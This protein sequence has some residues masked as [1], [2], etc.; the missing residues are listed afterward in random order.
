MYVKIDDQTMEGILR[1][2]DLDKEFSS[3]MKL[4]M[5]CKLSQHSFIP[6]PA[7]SMYKK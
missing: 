1:V 4:T 6:V 3:R 7:A 5:N 2:I